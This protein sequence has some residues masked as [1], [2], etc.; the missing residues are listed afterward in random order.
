MARRAG[1]DWLG[2]YDGLPRT[3]QRVDLFRYLVLYLDGGLYADLDMACFQPV[4]R[5]L[6]GAGCVLSVEAHLTRRRQRE[7]GYAR[8]VQLANCVLASRAGHPFLRGLLDRIRAAPAGDQADDDE[9]EDSTGPRA[10]TRHFYA[11]EAAR[12]DVRVLP[13]VFLMSPNE[14]PRLAPLSANL[15]ARHLTAWSWRSD[16][17]SKGAWRRW[18]ER[19]RLPNPFPALDH[20]ELL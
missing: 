17:V 1:A 9:V 4:D 10:L 20:L 11:S 6:A 8:P 7:L 19:N 12:R 15:Y 5:L 14:Y 2:L 13:Q 16:R 3:I 18:V